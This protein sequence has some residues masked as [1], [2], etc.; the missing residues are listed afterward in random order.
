M[1]FGNENEGLATPVRFVKGV[2][3][4][5]AEQLARMNILS[6]GDLLLT[7]PR[8]YEDRR[9]FARLSSLRSGETA[10]VKAPIAACAW[11]RP[12]YGKSYFEAALSDGSG[13]RSAADA[14][15]YA[16]WLFFFE[17]LWSMVFC[18]MLH[19]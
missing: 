19:P 9:F 15:S 18:V 4:A 5:R 17:G 12:R 11:V 7:L 16:V 8:R 6:V 14:T 3:E 13:A 1:V 10:T 2:G